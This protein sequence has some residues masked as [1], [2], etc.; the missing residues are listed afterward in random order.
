V[1]EEADLREFVLTE[2]PRVVAAVAL[3]SG[4]ESAAEDAVQ[5][6]LLRAWDRSRRGYEIGSVAGWVTT[7]ALNLSRS[8]LRRIIAERK[9]RHRLGMRSADAPSAD[10][11]DVARA[12]SLLPR[13][14]REVVV[15]RYLLDMTTSEAA[16][17]M[18]VSEGTVKSQ[19]ARARAA[20]ATMLDVDEE[21]T[22]NHAEA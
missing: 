5:E 2:Y 4:S 19:L 14:Q 7:V 12:V 10:R 6:A 22:S 11:L 1:L 15:L 3:V 20:L 16:E 8:G 13:R 9:A 21:A 17:T 18:R